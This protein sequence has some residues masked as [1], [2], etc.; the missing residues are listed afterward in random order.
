MNCHTN[1]YDHRLFILKIPLNF[2]S[3]LLFVFCILLI[4]AF[5]N[6]D[7]SMR[8][9]PVVDAVVILYIFRVFDL[10]YLHLNICTKWICTWNALVIII[11][12]LL[13]L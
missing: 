6:R 11:V 13:R 5:T 2:L 4:H 7:D 3:M 9:G 1:R 8:F 12:L 10:V